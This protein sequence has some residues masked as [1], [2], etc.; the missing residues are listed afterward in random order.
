MFVLATLI[1]WGNAYAQNSYNVPSSGHTNVTTCDAWIYD[2]GGANGNYSNNCNGYLVIYPSG[3]NT[4]VSITSGTYNT[5]GVSYDYIEIYNGV[6]TNGTPLVKLGGSGSITSPITSTAANGALTIRFISDFWATRSGFSLHVQCTPVVSMSSTMLSTC[7][8]T[9]TDPG[10]TGNY[11]SNQN[12]TQTICSDNGERLMVDFSL[13]SL[14][15]GDTLF[16]YDGNTTAADLLG[17]F[18]WNSSPGTIISSGACLTFRFVS[19]GYGNNSG[20]LALVSCSN[21]SSGN[22]PPSTDLGSPCAADNIHPF[23]TDEGQYVYESGVTGSAD[24][25]FD[26]PSSV[27]CLA[28]TPAPA[29]YYMRIA[30]PGDITIHITQR[31]LAPNLWGSYMGDVDFACW[32]PFTAQSSSDFIENLCCGFYSLNIDD[33]PDNTSPYANYPYPNLVDCSYDPAST[34]DCHI[35]NAQVGE[36]YLLLITNYERERGV[37]TFNST[38]TSTATTDC[39]I[40]VDVSND[41]P[42]C[43]GDTIHLICNNPSV[44]ASYS[45]TGPNGWTS[46]EVNPVIYP[47]TTAMNGNAYYLVKSIDGV[48]SDPD[49]TIISVS[50]KP[51]AEIIATDTV[52]CLGESV[53]LS[54]QCRPDTFFTELFDGIL[55]GNNAYPTGSLNQVDASD[56]VQF[57]AYS[58]IYMAGG[59]VKV[60]DQNIPGSMT[61]VPYDLTNPFTVLIGAKNWFGANAMMRV[62]VIDNNGVSH[63]AQNINVHQDWFEDYPV[64]FTGVSSGAKIKISKESGNPYFIDRISFLRDV[65][66]VNHWSPGGQTSQSITVSPQNTT[67]YILQQSV[68]PC[69]DYDTITIVVNQPT[70]NPD[71]IVRMVRSDAFP[72]SFNNTLFYAPGEYVLTTQNAAGCDSTYFLSL[73]LLPAVYVN[74]DTIVCKQSL[75]VQWHDVMFYGDSVASLTF[76]SASGADSIVQLSLSVSLNPIISVNLVDE[77]CAGDTLFVMI[78]S[79]ENATL[80]IDDNAATRG[81]TQK[82]F[83]P[84]SIDCPPYGSSYRSLANFTHF[85]SGAMVTSVNDIL[86]LRLKIEHSALEDLR[87]SVVCPTGQRSKLVADYNRETAQWDNIPNTGYRLNLGLANRLTDEL[88]CDSTLSPI[89]VPWDYVWSNNTTQNYQYANSAH[90]YCYEQAN[91]QLYNNP[92]WDSSPYHYSVKPSNLNNRSQIYHPYQSFS[93]LVGCPLNGEWYI[94]IQDMMPDD[95]GYLVEWEL[96]MDPSLLRVENPPVVSRSLTGPWVTRLTD[97]TFIVTPPYNLAHD[98]TATYVFHIQDS[99]GCTFDTLTNVTFFAHVSS[100]YDTAVCSNDLPITWRDELF[101]AAGSR[102]LT[103]T[104]YHGCDS[105]VTLTL[106]TK[107]A[108]TQNVDTSVCVGDLPITWNGMN[109]SQ[110]FLATL[111]PTSTQPPTFAIVD[112]L[113]GAAANQCDSIVTLH[114]TLTQSVVARPVDTIICAADL[115]FVWNE[116]AITQ[117]DL[118]SHEAEGMPPVY[119]FV[120]TLSRASLNGCDSIIT[121]HLTVNR[122]V[123]AA[124]V[125]TIVCADDLPITWLNTTID[126]HYLELLEETGAQPPTYIIVDTIER[127]AAN[128]CDSIVTL[129]LTVNQPSDPETVEV[130]ACGEYTWIDGRTYT[131]S[132][133]TPTHIL[134]N[135]AGCD[136]VL[137]LHLTIFPKPQACFVVSALDDNYEL[138]ATLHFE[139]CSPGMANYEWSMGNMVT[140]DMPS[141]DYVYPHSGYYHVTLKVTDAN[142]CTD[143]QG[144]TVSIH[145][146]ETQVFFANTFTPNGDGLN[147]IFKPE[148]QHIMPEGY[149]L[150]IYDRWGVKVFSSTDPNYGWD[151]TYMGRL[152]PNNSVMSYTFRCITEYGMIR[153]KG[154][155]TVVY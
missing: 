84:D 19:N 4:L 152:V 11:S 132:T 46:N 108:V 121:L 54:A 122:P 154:A 27:G 50:P 52:I 15:I 148:G 129:R 77:T 35:T 112:T 18:S 48:D 32:G 115:P 1:G 143:E 130:T 142:G 67:Q 63:Q 131:Y 92:Y 128:G 72:Y 47:A 110:S 43:E 39:S 3:N 66:C 2:N 140:F 28:M 7:N 125:E 24:G 133:N 26:D 69:D 139:E 99:I 116:T 135:M 29:W 74:L 146:P 111:V 45:W 85:Q 147:D 89:G 151:G 51:I 56:M 25:F 104:S 34:E 65:Q 38:P 53:T 155:V 109:I 30:D 75:P 150:V 58:N 57:S 136:S 44:G 6:G 86:Y 71:T 70:V 64:T 105:L 68:G 31:L 55:S 137:T 97:S 9:W 102:E 101:T 114:L 98:T 17:S 59:A 80:Q 81:E 73:R 93:N 91:I 134:S 21:C 61:S 126:Q 78:S 141:F 83:L 82:V 100:Q 95:N 40:M 41:G 20:W 36:Y 117:Q 76:L 96:A 113:F 149:S 124:R 37:I 118:D 88:D 145:E 16:V 144:K 120:D 62:E 123:E 103:R 79:D 5:E 42:Y 106:T 22:H 23:C 13:F 90:S 127:A 87:M 94:E 119:T 107:H 14:Y 10:G 49:T 138:G 153:Q 60:G 12:I 8:M 33:H